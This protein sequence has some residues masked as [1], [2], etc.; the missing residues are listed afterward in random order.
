SSDRD[1][2]SDVCTSDLFAFVTTMRGVPAGSRGRVN[3][4]VCA[5]TTIGAA[6]IAPSNVT[7]APAAK[8][9]PLIVSGVPPSVVAQIGATRVTRSEER[10]VGR[11]WRFGG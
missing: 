7:T 6:A 11:E 2:S 3:V 1:W 8:P 4:I 5:S 10:R 9:E